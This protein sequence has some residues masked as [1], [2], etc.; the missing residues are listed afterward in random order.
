MAQLAGA[1]VFYKLDANSE[2]YQIPLDPKSTKV[3]T[4]I[5]LFS[6]YYY[7]RL[8]IGITSAPK[9]FHRRISKNFTSVTGT[10]SMMD[11]FLIFGKNQEEHDKHLAVVLK[12]DSRSLA[13]FE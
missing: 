7:S 1:K 5:T 6:R 10:V 2:F 9:H 4:F 13:N 12:K 3:T 11:D 8:P